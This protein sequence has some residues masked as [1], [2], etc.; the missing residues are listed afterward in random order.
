MLYVL[1]LSAIAIDLKTK[2]APFAEGFQAVALNQATAAN[3]L[4]SDDDSNYVIA[5]TLGAGD[6]AT[7]VAQTE[8]LKRYVKSSAATPIFLLG[9]L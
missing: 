7:A 8:P 5:A 3:V 9:S 4:H 1:A 2:D 6:S